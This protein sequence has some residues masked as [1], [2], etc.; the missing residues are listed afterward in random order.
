MSQIINVYYTITDLLWSYKKEKFRV[1]ERHNETG[2][3][4]KCKIFPLSHR[5]QI[6]RFQ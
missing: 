1:K 2:D 6:H 5:L 4:Q 3:N